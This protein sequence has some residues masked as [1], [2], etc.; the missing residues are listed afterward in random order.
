ML[1]FEHYAPR[2]G[3]LVFER[4][5]ASPVLSAPSTASGAP[6]VT[7]PPPG[8]ADR[9]V[10]TWSK[11]DVF[12]WLCGIG[13]VYGDY[14]KAFEDEGITGKELLS[15]TAEDLEDFGVTKER[16]KKRILSEIDAL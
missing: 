5:G 7:A 10:N 4:K 2:K 11:A 15:L 9:P 3:T 13:K 14:T 6:P 12:E 1:S 16:H 8:K